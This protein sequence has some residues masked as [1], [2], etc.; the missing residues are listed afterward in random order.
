MAADWLLMFP[1][2]SRISLTKGDGPSGSAVHAARIS[3]SIAFCAAT[4][5]S[6]CI[7]PAVWASIASLRLLT[8]GARWSSAIIISSS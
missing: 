8:S 4:I 5:F 7:S 2:R 3:L 6:I 1:F